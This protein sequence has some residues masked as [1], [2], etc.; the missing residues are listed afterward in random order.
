LTATTSGAYPWTPATTSGPAAFG[1]DIAGNNAD[2][3]VINNDISG[4]T[5]AGVRVGQGANGTTAVG[6]SNNTLT[7]NEV[8]LVTLTTG[9]T[10]SLNDLSGNTTASLETGG[11]LV[12]ADL[13]DAS[14]NWW[15][16]PAPA[17]NPHVAGLINDVGNVDYTPWLGLGTDTDAVA[18]GFQAD[19][20][21]AFV[22]DDSPQTGAVGRAGS[23]AGHA[24]R[25]LPAAPTALKLRATAALRCPRSQPPL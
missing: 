19:L 21:S 22:D 24:A 15:G 23:R 2:I 14:A 11:A 5:T 18:I 7:G 8:G 25:S 10:I 12:A 17:D 9:L 1:V 13:V 6:V 4:A 3:G 16:A 20:S